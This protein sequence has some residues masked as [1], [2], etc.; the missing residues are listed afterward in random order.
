MACTYIEDAIV[1]SKH[2]F[3]DHLKALENVLQ[4]IMEAGLKVNVVK[5]LF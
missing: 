3:V 2:N 5:S 4:K 1:I